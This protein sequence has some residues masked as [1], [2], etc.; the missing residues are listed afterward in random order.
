M[1]KILFLLGICFLSLNMINAQSVKE[2]NIFKYLGTKDYKKYI[3]IY[4]RPNNTLVLKVYP[5]QEYMGSWMKSSE[6]PRKTYIATYDGNGLLTNVDSENENE[7]SVYTYSNNALYCI[8]RYNKNTGS[9]LSTEYPNDLDYGKRGKKRIT[10]NDTYFTVWFNTEN[11]GGLTVD[12]SACAVS[13]K[14]YYI[15]TDSRYYFSSNDLR[16]ECGLSWGNHL[17]ESDPYNPVEKMLKKDN[18][19]LRTAV[20]LDS[21]GIPLGSVRKYSDVVSYNN[22]LIIGNDYYEYTWAY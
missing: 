20:R 22:Y 9:R 2:N 16:K 11:S 7:K 14:V 12:F 17:G 10:V 3:P 21:N 19:L 13:N 6:Y 8:T 4:G 18:L 5:A 15:T 1:K